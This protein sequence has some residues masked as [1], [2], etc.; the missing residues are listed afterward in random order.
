[1]IAMSPRL[2]GPTWLILA[3]MLALVGAGAMAL[4]RGPRSVP[5]LDE[6]CALARHH[7]FDR[8]EDLM[9]GYLRAFPGDSRA[10]LLMAQFA[11]DRPDPEPQRA[12][13]HLGEI[14]PRTSQEAAVVRFSEGKAQYLQKGYILAEAC[15]KQALKL[16]PM[17]PE[18]GWAL[19]DLLDFEG[20]VV[21]AHQ[22]G[23]QL[24]NSEPDPRDQA[25]LLLEMSRIDIDR[26][27]PGSQVQV[28][29]PVWKQNPENL[30]LGVA[31]GLAL[32]HD[33]Q[34]EKGIEVL[35]TVLQQ[36][37]DSAQVWD[38]WLTGLDDGFQ[39]HQ[40]E[41]EFTRL[42]QVLVTDPRFAKHEGTAAQGAHNW[43]RA[44]AA[45][46]R[47]HAFEP[48]N[49][50]VL[51]RL[52]MALR[53]VGETADFHRIDELLT[54]Y[55]TAFKQMRAVYTEAFSV[56]TLGVAPHTELYHRLAGLREQLGRFDEARAWHRLVLRDVP[57]DA[58]SLAALER[59][60]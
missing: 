8:A 41:R 35:R 60:K 52:R 46:Q 45:Y 20:R 53:A 51:Y 44:I 14:H 9:A 21:E 26:I 28:F 33:S 29:E 2:G 4:W 43:A 19:L 55:Q 48:S 18:A 13:D 6:I 36:H 58:L 34:S 39:P 54:T 5:N 40:L 30:A 10:H 31:V 42:P 49:G 59:L 47:A 23:M 7:Q 11:L 1:M 50:V 22:L 32:V 57:D 3:G 15:W 16:D 12:L 56:K 27:A 38:A 17:V 37:P 25:R 24:F